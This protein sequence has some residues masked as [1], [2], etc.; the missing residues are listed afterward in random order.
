V[1]GGQHGQ[2]LRR[3]FDA[4]LQAVEEEETDR[5]PTATQNDGGAR[6]VGRESKRR[7]RPVQL[8]LGDPESSSGRG[9]LCRQM[10]YL[11]VA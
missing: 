5:P 9:R 8:N 7:Q 4:R 3:H 10:A 11:G 1:L 6:L 2:G